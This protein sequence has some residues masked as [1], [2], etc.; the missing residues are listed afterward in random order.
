MARRKIT[1][2]MIQNMSKDDLIKRIHNQANNINKKRNEFAEAYHGEAYDEMIHAML[3]DNLFRDSGTVNKN[4][5]FYSNFEVFELRQI[6]VNMVNINNHDVFG[7]VNKYGLIKDDTFTVLRGTVEE[8][9][10]SRGY[11]EDDI[12]RITHEKSFYDNL[13]IAFKEKREFDSDNTIEKVYLSYSDKTDDD[14]ADRINRLI[15]RDNFARN[16]NEERELARRLR[17]EYEDRMNFKRDLEDA[18]KNK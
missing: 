2:E 18:R 4:K 14:K 12:N 9:L 16:L 3:G 11:D 10:T 6:M 7:T 1:N 13:L 5:K 8:I 15:E 17:Q